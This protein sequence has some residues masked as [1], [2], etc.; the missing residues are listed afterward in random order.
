MGVVNVLNASE[1]VILNWLTFVLCEC[2]LSKKI[3]FK[4]KLLKVGGVRV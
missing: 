2:P 1:L 3:N 4:K